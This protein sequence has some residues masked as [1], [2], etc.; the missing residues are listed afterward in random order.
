MGTICC[1]PSDSGTSSPQY[2]QYW[3]LDIL[4]DQKGKI[5]LLKELMSHNIITGDSEEEIKIWNLE[6]R[7][8]RK[9]IDLSGKIFFILEFE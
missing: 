9:T 3:L 8:Y 7:S 2:T 5:M 4:S 1:P 6:N